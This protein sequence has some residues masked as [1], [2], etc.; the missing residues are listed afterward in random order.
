[1]DESD[2]TEILWN[3][4]KYRHSVYWNLLFRFG[5]AIV[6]LWVIP[7]VRPEVFAPWRGIA[8]LFPLTALALSV[9]ST[10]L[11]AAEQSRLSAIRRKLCQKCPA[12]GDSELPAIL[13]VRLAPAIVVLYC[14]SLSVISILATILV[15]AQKP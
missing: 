15:F 4:W 12:L 11:L 5:G 8:S 3:E 14:M 1:M 10:W 9:F 7:F 6:V 2:Q 13:A